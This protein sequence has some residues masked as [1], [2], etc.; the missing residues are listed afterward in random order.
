MAD[1]VLRT[2]VEA[3]VVVAEASKPVKVTTDGRT[4]IE[5]PYLDYEG[6]TG[7]PFL[8]EYFQLGDGWKDKMGGFE[9]EIG[10]LED[11][12]KSKIQGGKTANSLSAVKEMIKRIEKVCLA[13]KT[14]RA[15]MKT[16][17][18][19]AYVEFLKKTD[20]ISYNNFRYSK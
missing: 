11:Y 6:L 15:T 13:D 5:P 14:E 18:M 7:H 20:D 17:K 4:G 9:K 19:A 3:P 1:T 10:I 16:E 8:V 12:V 2:Q